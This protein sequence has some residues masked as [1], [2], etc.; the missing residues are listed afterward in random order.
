MAEAAPVSHL[1]SAQK[2]RSVFDGQFL[3]RYLQAEQLPGVT[4]RVGFHRPVWSLNL[5]L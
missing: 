1:I 4:L 5:P 3:L 2:I